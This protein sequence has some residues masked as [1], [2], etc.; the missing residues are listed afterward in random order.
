MTDAALELAFLGPPRVCLRGQAVRFDTRKALAL[1]AYLTLSRQT[2]QRA[3]LA[4]LL[5]PESEEGRA[6]NA[7]RR[8]LSTLH[9][10]LEKRGLVLGRSAVGLDPTLRY[11]L[12]VDDFHR[13]IAACDACEHTGPGPCAACLARLE[14]ATRLATG[15][16]LE[17]F[18]VPG[19]EDFS[20]WLDFQRA[21]LRDARWRALETLGA[22]AEQRG[23]W[24]RAA[25]LTRHQLE[26]APFEE[27]ASR[28]L[29][30][31]AGRRGAW[32]EGQ[33]LYRGLVERLARE[34]RRAPEPATQALH[35]ALLE[36][37][38]GTSSAPAAA[39][40]GALPPPPRALPAA[41]TP[42]IGRE[43]ELATLLAWLEEP[44]TRLVT[45]AGPGGV[46]KTRLAIELAARLQEKRAD[47]AR[48]I[49]LEGLDA[50]E[51]LAGR[52]AEALRLPFDSGKDVETRL[53]DALRHRSLVLLL[54]NFE[55]LVAGAPQLARWL[56]EAPGLQLVVTSRER[57]RLGAE[58][59]FELGGLRRDE[60]DEA[61]ALLLGCAA[62]AVPLFAT[63]AAGRE[64]LREVCELL[65]GHPLALE[66]AASWLGLVPPA[67]LLARLRA[68]LEL[69]AGGFADLP[70]RQRGLRGVFDTTW[71]LLAPR[72]RASFARLT[73]FRGSFSRRAAT[74]VAD[75]SLSSLLALSDRFLL[76]RD[77]PGRF[78]LH[79]LLRG[80]A[81]EQLGA[82][83]RE[84]LAA[85][86]AAYFGTSLADAAPRLWSA[87]QR[88]VLEALAP[89]LDNLRAAWRHAL[90]APDTAWLEAA[91]PP[92]C[93]ALV[94]W[95][96]LAEGASLCR[97]TRAAL[98]EESALHGRLLAREGMFARRLGAE[99]AAELLDAAL[100]RLED[101]AE[102]AFAA[103]QR[104]QLCLARGEHARAEELLRASL[105]SA[106]G[107]G[108]ALGRTRCLGHLGELAR[109]RGDFEACA[110]LQEEALDAA[111]D[112]E[113]PWIYGNLLNDLGMIAGA[114]GDYALARQRFEAALERFR[115]LD[116]RAGVAASL[117]N[118]ASVAYFEQ[119]YERARALREESLTLCRALGHRMQLA[120][121]LTAL[122]N[123]E[124]RLEAVESATERYAESRALA[125]E[126]G[127]PLGE[128]LA[129]SSLVG[130]RVR[131]GDGAGARADLR[132][133]RA[134][135]PG[136]PTA[137]VALHAVV[138]YAELLAAE[139]RVERAGELA[140][141]V[142]ADPRVE[143]QVGRA[144]RALLTRLGLPLP[145]PGPACEPGTLLAALGEISEVD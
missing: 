109:L 11:A 139:H 23:E 21:E 100:A 16:L 92:L 54:D 141:A 70:A 32:A 27:G 71:E 131:A 81:A 50:P 122:G 113:V 31:I 13:L 87:E 94:L 9:S 90:V 51:G 84:R 25:R 107:R 69:S 28:R 60:G 145:E 102:R 138:Q 62:R 58:R 12:D 91:V 88:A 68:R 144:A 52:V 83:A 22:A 140:R 73:V 98:P 143:A 101:D 64:A 19:A 59:L 1:L 72:E 17:G 79:G 66:L 65:E 89:D 75:L 2:F 48:L 121:A 10:G 117:Q 53:G 137:Q 40:Q 15:P 44:A 126:L 56:A 18:E 74:A 123:V 38:L 47:G 67:G 106:T 132:A 41:A 77:G 8:T 111:S 105:A 36:R 57:L 45:I 85:R 43:R 95:G 76:R 118:L 55:Q 120:R 78:A 49:C 128:S 130:L 136:L 4:A 142:A 104:G 24:D 7:L 80:Y 42:F 63:D 127:D 35:R 86:H 96:R 37:R 116:A 14:E 6:R 34:H 5:W 108:D 134:L 97:A 93:E 103:M 135:L 119:D 133:L 99:A 46:G 112:V 124:E 115:A 125:R 29:M 82:P 33:A 20:R 26:L 114:R 39:P 110:S 61:L 129:L 30:R 3:T